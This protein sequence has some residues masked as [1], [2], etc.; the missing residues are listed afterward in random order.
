MEVVGYRLDRLDNP[1]F[2]TVP[3]LM[4]TEFGII[5]CRVV[6]P[7]SSS[8]CFLSFFQ[9]NNF[10]LLGYYN[11]PEQ[12]QD[13]Q[14]YSAASGPSS[15]PRWP[16]ITQESAATREKDQLEPPTKPNFIPGKANNYFLQQ[17]WRGLTCSTLD[18]H[19][20]DRKSDISTRV[21][22]CAAKR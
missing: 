2:M 17:T 19:S 4:P 22:F 13:Q 20:S 6:T 9:S 15:S 5:D 14:L 12:P 11:M 8:V 21:N 18:F 16:Q 7:I 10:L 1:F 3:K